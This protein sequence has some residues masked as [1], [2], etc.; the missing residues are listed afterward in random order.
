[1][2]TDC[3]GFLTHPAFGRFFISPPT[4]HF[5]EG[6]FPL[7]LFLQD[8]QCRIDIVV[9]HENLHE[10]PIS[11]TC[12]VLLYPARR[13]SPA[14][15]RRPPPQASFASKSPPRAFPHPRARGR[16]A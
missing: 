10:Q 5:A 16:H 15:R 11:S 12:C 3:L 2:P 4:L 6:A 14:H 1:M 7:H 8:P 9:A 13:G